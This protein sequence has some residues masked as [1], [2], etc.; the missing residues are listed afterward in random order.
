VACFV[1]VFLACFVAFFLALFLALV[2]SSF[3]HLRVWSCL[4]CSF[5]RSPTCSVH[6]CRVAVHNRALLLPNEGTSI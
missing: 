5:V 6:G 1:A 4:P 2:V 3:T